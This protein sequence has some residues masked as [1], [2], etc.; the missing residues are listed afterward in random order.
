LAA[1]VDA[2]NRAYGVHCGSLAALKGGVWIVGAMGNIPW[3]PSVKRAGEKPIN[4][5]ATE[6]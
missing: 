6:R 4:G 2:A 1:N 3:A 5:T